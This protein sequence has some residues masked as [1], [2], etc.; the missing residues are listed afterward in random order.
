M[1]VPGPAILNW[2]TAEC[3]YC[4]R[5]V[6]IVGAPGL[7]PTKD[8]IIP[9]VLGDFGRFNVVRACADCNHLKNSRTPP[10]MRLLAHMAEQQAR[11]WRDMADTVDRLLEERGLIAPWCGEMVG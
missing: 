7:R 6:E 11:R 8:H 5:D 10:E 2:D 4:G 3:V 9:K 1:S